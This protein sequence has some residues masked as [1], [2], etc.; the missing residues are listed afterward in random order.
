MPQ[1]FNLKEAIKLAVE[2]EKE[3]MDFYTKAASITKNE[4]GKKVFAQ[5]A[6]E[7]REHASHFFDIYPGDDLGTFEEFMQQ[8]ETFKSSVVKRMEKA[9]TEN[10]HDRKALEIA[11]EEEEA[12]AKRLRQTAAHIIDPAVRT[13]FDQMAEETERHFAIIESEYA[14]LMGMVHETDI[15]TYVRE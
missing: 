2:T 12:L 1:E 4:R 6:K 13:V 10:I 9:L 15:D 3:A 5:L 7:E 11:L 8:P 14:H